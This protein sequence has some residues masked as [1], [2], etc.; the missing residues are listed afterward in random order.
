MLQ[1]RR[2]TLWHNPAALEH[3][4]LS[5]HLEHPKGKMIT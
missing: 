3:Y 5:Y 2:I 1:G 4:P